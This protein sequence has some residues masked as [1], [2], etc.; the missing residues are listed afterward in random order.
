MLAATALIELQDPMYQWTDVDRKVSR[1]I[2]VWFKER[3]FVLKMANRG[4][5]YESLRQEF[6]IE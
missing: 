6:W 1:E 4:G 2:L 3:L 5:D